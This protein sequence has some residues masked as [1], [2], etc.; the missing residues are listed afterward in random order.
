M[1]VPFQSEKWR[2]FVAVERIEE[3][4]EVDGWLEEGMINWLE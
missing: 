2:I 1:S 4:R 3:M